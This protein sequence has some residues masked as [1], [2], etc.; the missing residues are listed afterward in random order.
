MTKRSKGKGKRAAPPLDSRA[1]KAPPVAER[2][3]LIAELMAA[4]TWRSRDALRLAEEWG[5]DSSTVRNASAEASRLVLGTLGDPEQI[6]AKLLGHLDEAIELA[7]G[8]PMPAKAAQAIVGAVAAFAKI[9]GTEAPSKVA[10]T[11]S[12]G[13]D[14]PPL[15]A[16]LKALVDAD[17]RL[18]GFALLHQ[19]PPTEEERKAIV[20]K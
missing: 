17:E 19:R 11:N 14:V 4:G 2:V 9:T 12:D 16:Q 7:R 13:E 6:R 10:L 8:D 5:V 15:P 20:G 3:K 1:R 18:L